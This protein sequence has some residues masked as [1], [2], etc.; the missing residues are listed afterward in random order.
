MNLHS[1]CSS[2]TFYLGDFLLA[3]V[4]NSTS[5]SFIFCISI[6]G[7]ILPVLRII[8]RIKL[9]DVHEISVGQ[10]LTCSKPSMKGSGE[11]YIVESN[12]K[13]CLLVMSLLGGQM[14]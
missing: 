2:I 14:T 6:L 13:I 7:I 1:N 12:N 9:D 3:C 10:C 5:L 8:E 4:N 11:P